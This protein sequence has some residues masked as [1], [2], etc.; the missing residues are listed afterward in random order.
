MRAETGGLCVKVSY[1]LSVLTKIENFDKLQWNS[2]N[3][4]RDTVRS[5]WGLSCFP[6]VQVPE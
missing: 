6:L 1:F 5:N 3:I 2:M 4:G